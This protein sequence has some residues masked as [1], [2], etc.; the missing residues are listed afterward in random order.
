MSL[1]F[2][3]LINA[4]KAL[5]DEEV[6][7][8]IKSALKPDFK[9]EILHKSKTN[10]K[11]RFENLLSLSFRLLKD[12]EGKAELENLNEIQ[13]L[14]R[15]FSEQTTSDDSKSG[16]NVK[17][18]KE[19]SSGSL[20]SAYDEDSTYRKKGGKASSGYV[21]NLSE[22]CS[23]ENPVQFIT[24]YTL[25]KN[26]VTDIDMLIERLP[27]IVAQ[28][29]V[30]DLY[31]DGGYYSERLEEVAEEL[32]VNLHYTNMTGRK[33]KFP[34]LPLTSFEVENCKT[35]ISCPM[36]FTPIKSE[37]KKKKKLVVAEFDIE[38][39]LKCPLKNICPVEIRKKKSLLREATKS[40]R[41]AK[42][43][44]EIESKEIRKMVVS[45]RAAIEGTNSSLKRSQGAGKLT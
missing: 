30:K 15:F 10:S 25:K 45:K 32:D 29:K 39:C 37:Y 35:I 28:S 9:T 8:F 12:I 38:Q 34:K 18:N 31:I 42:R 44:A 20:Q 26:I 41:A 24:D 6:P 17:E 1:A 3:V 22:T 19:I 11:S 36:G 16:F 5:P 21:L 14:K 7:E 13:I 2:D 33:T 40:L 4:A 23:I 27:I 43:R